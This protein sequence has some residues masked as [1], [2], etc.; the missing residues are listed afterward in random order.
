MSTITVII[1]SCVQFSTTKL[2]FPD[3]P[4][5]MNSLEFLEQVFVRVGALPVTVIYI[6]KFLSEKKTSK[7]ADKDPA[8]INQGSK[9]HENRGGG[10]L[11]VTTTQTSPPH[12]FIPG[13]KP[14]FPANPSHRSLPF[15]LQD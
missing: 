4:G 10:N 9:N 6:T 2:F 11:E 3:K 5:Q 8:R 7:K 14:S 15:L 1:N 12:S 13:L